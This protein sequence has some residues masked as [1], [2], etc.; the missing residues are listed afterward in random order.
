VYMKCASS[1]DLSLFGKGAGA[2]PTAT[3]VLGDLIDLAQDNSVRW[4]APQSLPIA[5]ANTSS[6]PLPRRHYLRVVAQ[7]HPGLERR[8]ESLVRHLGLAVQNRASRGGET[9]HYLGFMISPSTDEQMA[10]V[11]DAVGR[12]ARVEQCLSLGVFE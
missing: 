10:T 11:L 3:A 12:L 4:P 7:P 9:S 1:G 5:R 6:L 2:L 8:I